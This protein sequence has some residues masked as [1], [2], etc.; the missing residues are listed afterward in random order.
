MI[1]IPFGKYEVSIDALKYALAATNEFRKLPIV[2]FRATETNLDSDKIHLQSDDIEKSIEPIVSDYPDINVSVEVRNGS[3]DEA[4]DQFISTHDVRMVIAGVRKTNGL[5]KVVFEGKASRFLRTIKSPILLI[6]EGFQYKPV[7]IILFASD[8]K[9]IANDDALDPLVDIAQ[10]RHAEVRIAHVRTDKRHLNE[11]EVMEMHRESSLFGDDIKHSFKH[12]FRSTIS[13]GI[14][15][16]LKLKGDNDLL[17]LIKREKGFLDR[18]F[19]K[20]HALEFALHPTL[21]VLILHES[22][23]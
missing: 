17:V 4:I 2:C 1:L 5:Q 15:Y 14:E 6:P 3:Y 22:G 12:I 21:P 8:F 16:Y 19:G 18:Q 23:S 20:D 9:P 10:V 7:E 11:D 13:K